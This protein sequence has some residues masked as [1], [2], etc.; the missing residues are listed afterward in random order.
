MTPVSR[1]QQHLGWKLFVSYLIIVIVG[2]V[3]LITTAAF[4]TP[5]A[6]ARHTARMQ[7]LL[8][9][10]PILIDE[11]HADFRAAI[12]E[13][14]AVAA[15]AATG[16]AVAVSVFTTRRIVGPIQA[17][18]RASRGI[19]GGD[20]HGRVQVPSQDE[21]G[22]LGQT[23]NRMAETLERTEQRRLALIGD[24]AHELRTPLSS[25]KSTME[26]LV[27]GVL[28]AE[29]ATFL[30]VQREVTRLQRLIDDLAQ[31]SRAEAGQLL[32]ERRA[33]A[34][35]EVIRGAVDRLRPQFEDKGV[36]LRVDL[37]AELP[38]VWADPHRLTQVLLNL[39]GN[40]LQYTRPGGQVTI[41][42]WCE[43]RAVATA[44]QD[45]GIGIAPEHLAHL[46]ERFYRVDKSR[47]RAGGGS[48]IGLTIAKHLVEA[49]GGRIWATSSGPG[50]GS[51]FTFT[52][53][54]AS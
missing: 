11:L 52:L 26:G 30:S 42:A 46:F 44:V 14:L 24:V 12:N 6:L 37:P 53:P 51:T 35:A 20:Y 48:G 47:S 41:R 43:G 15:L 3:V 16:A 19:A 27:D 49:H 17:M 22:I 39:L 38:H 40:A 2:V 13:V 54:V 21:L 18:T 34:P 45:T 36:R 33:V 23:F 29:P 8:G 10:D 4:H 32:L 5:A 9:A 50:Q 25:I 31:L 28:P 1:L 7:A